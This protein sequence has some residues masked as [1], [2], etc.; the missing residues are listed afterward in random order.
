MASGE[1]V[2]RSEWVTRELRSA[3]LSGVFAPG[4]RLLTPELTQ[5]FSVS[6]TPLREALQA[7]ASEGIVEWTPQRGARVAPISESE[8]RELHELR[9]VVQPMAV[10]L[11]L[12]HGGD[13]WLAGVEAAFVTYRRVLRARKASTAELEEAHR[14]FHSAVISGCG[15]TWLIRLN[16]LLLQGSARYRSVAFRVVKRKT[17]LTTAEDLLEAC[18][19][20]I[21]GDAVRATVADIESVMVILGD[22]TDWLVAQS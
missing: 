6:P 18:R 17:C 14:E 11:S 2:T 22:S 5:R 1:P 12:K 21:E 3:I 16:Q 9:L 7:L 20:R 8:C 10:G 19:R 4:D 13:G 15:N